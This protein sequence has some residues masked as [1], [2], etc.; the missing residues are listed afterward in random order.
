MEGDRQEV[1]QAGEICGIHEGYG[2]H[3]R[4]MEGI[5]TTWAYVQENSRTYLKRIRWDVME[6]NHLPHDCGQ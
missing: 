2:C 6:Q 3:T 5:N 4:R 1:K